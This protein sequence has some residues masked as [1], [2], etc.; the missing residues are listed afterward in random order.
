MKN[1]GVCKL[2]YKQRP[3]KDMVRHYPKPRS[4]KNSPSQSFNDAIVKASTGQR[5]TRPTKVSN[6]VQSIQQYEAEILGILKRDYFDERKSFTQA[7]IAARAERVVEATMDGT[8]NVAKDR[9]TKQ[10]LIGDGILAIPSVQDGILPIGS[11][12]YKSFIRNEDGTFK[13]Y[14]WLQQRNIL[15][16]HYGEKPLQVVGNMICPIVGYLIHDREDLNLIPNTYLPRNPFYAMFMTH[17]MWILVHMSESMRCLCKRGNR[18]FSERLQLPTITILK[19]SKIISVY[20]A[21]QEIYTI[22]TTY[23]VLLNFKTDFA[24]SWENMYPLMY[25]V[26]QNVHQRLN[27]PA[28]V[29]HQRVTHLEMEIKVVTH[30]TRPI[31]TASVNFQEKLRQRQQNKTIVAQKVVVKNA[32]YCGPSPHLLQPECDVVFVTTNRGYY[33]EQSVPEPVSVVGVYFGE[34][35]SLQAELK[36][37]SHSMFGHNIPMYSSET[38]TMGFCKAVQ[39]ICK[40]RYSGRDNI[41]RMDPKKNFPSISAQYKP[42]VCKSALLNF[43]TMHRKDMDM[44]EMY[45]YHSASNCSRDLSMLVIGANA[46]TPYELHKAKHVFFGLPQGKR[47]TQ[48]FCPNWDYVSEE[49]YKN[50]LETLQYDAHYSE[51]Q[52]RTFTACIQSVLKKDNSGRGANETYRRAPSE[53]RGGA[54][55]SRSSS[56]RRAESESR[57]PSEMPSS[58]QSSMP[59]DSVPPGNGRESP[60]YSGTSPPPAESIPSSQPSAAR[61]ASAPDTLSGGA[62]SPQTPRQSSGPSASS[63]TSAVPAQPPSE[64]AL[65]NALPFSREQAL[66]G[67]PTAPAG[68]EDSW[69]FADRKKYY[70]DMYNYWRQ[71]PQR[72]YCSMYDYDLYYK[73][74][75]WYFAEE[76]GWMQWMDT[77]RKY[78]MPPGMPPEEMTKCLRHWKLHT[79]HSD[80]EVPFIPGYD[81]P[82]DQKQRTTV[83]Q[84]HPMELPTPRGRGSQSAASSRRA[85]PDNMDSSR[86]GS[87]RAGGAHPA[88]A[89]RPPSPMLQSRPASPGPPQDPKPPKLKGNYTDEE[90]RQNVNQ[91]IDWY[92]NHPDEAQRNE[93]EL[94]ELMAKSLRLNVR[95][96][97]RP[98][99]PKS[100]ASNADRLAYYTELLAWTNKHKTNTENEKQQ[101]TLIEATKKHFEKLVQQDVAMARAKSRQAKSTSSSDESNGSVEESPVATTTPPNGSVEESPVATTTPPN[102][103]DQSQTAPSPMEG[104]DTTKP[105]TP[106]GDHDPSQSDM[107]TRLNTYIQWYE[108]FERLVKYCE[109]KKDT[110][111]ACYRYAQDFLDYNH[112]D[113]PPDNWKVTEAFAT[114]ES[115]PAPIPQNCKNYYAKQQFFQQVVCWYALHYD[116]RN[117]ANGMSNDQWEQFRLADDW[118]IAASPMF[119]PDP[120]NKNIYRDNQTKEFMETEQIRTKKARR[121]EEYEVSEDGSNRP[122]SG[123]RR[124]ADQEGVVEMYDSPDNGVAGGAGSISDNGRGGSNDGFLAE[125]DPMGFYSERLTISEVIAAALQPS[126]FDEELYM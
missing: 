99:A 39:Q 88:L 13:Y 20:T 45:N 17:V 28:V 53:S 98:S 111:Y 93:R 75:N 103:S 34:G 14:N 112:H 66:A 113:A 9:I 61:P 68:T 92:S 102:G 49:E 59:R 124:Q 126:I 35:I 73:M 95:I 46:E 60:T 115:W 106:G 64:T 97:S 72:S 33:S 44:E 84:Y 82:A 116:L 41:S 110:E 48:S 78:G 96:N 125:F 32:R 16:R 120:D 77:T 90:L 29:V 122:A 91:W 62:A 40:Q 101:L 22:T 52:K 56:Y 54:Q 15:T 12:I 121:R 123:R 85:S 7:L 57:E 25:A 76:R 43:N 118:L 10:H 70:N 117:P 94:K 42:T 104:S 36:H 100:N 114:G 65:L 1:D 37:M 83:V 51:P 47:S 55:A 74:Y 18:I 5:V 31:M 86:P 38:T 108:Y 87:P 11:V 107:I 21:T 4:K 105:R 50:L 2:L 23:R 109:E 67:Q 26:M 79:N 119:D 8:G 80:D 63:G 30:A 27:S 89:T 69:S 6:I 81:N 3:K 58:R 71:E 24:S 19:R